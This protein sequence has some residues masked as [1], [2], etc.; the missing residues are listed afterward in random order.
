M[1]G[2]GG[3]VEYKK[4]IYSGG[5]G[6]VGSLSFW[7]SPTLF[8]SSTPTVRLHLHVA[9]SRP[10]TI[11]TG[12]RRLVFAAAH[13]GEMSRS[14]WFGKSWSWWWWL[15]ERLHS[16]LWRCRLL[17]AHPISSFEKKLER[18]ILCVEEWCWCGVF[19][20]VWMTPS[21][22]HNWKPGL[23]KQVG[24]QEG[25][26]GKGENLGEGEDQMLFICLCNCNRL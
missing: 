23:N 5:P 20:N 19:S 3:V 26:G 2:G 21:W 25:D 4:F 17:Q 24:D 10:E 22:Q 6:R 12:P 18:L 7:Y 16:Q 14:L 13:L 8:K 11:T 1:G 15:P 9:A